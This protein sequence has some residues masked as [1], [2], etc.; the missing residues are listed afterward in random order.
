[1][2]SGSAVLGSHSQRPL[3]I[4]KSLSWKWVKISTLVKNKSVNA[5]Y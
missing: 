5:E 2:A 1:M 3:E 4:R